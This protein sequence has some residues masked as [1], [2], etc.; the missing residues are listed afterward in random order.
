V[1]AIGEEG[2]LKEVLGE[3]YDE[4]VGGLLLN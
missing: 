2:D 3:R 1:E 4:L